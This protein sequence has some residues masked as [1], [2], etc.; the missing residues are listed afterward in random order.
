[1]A[2]ICDPDFYIPTMPR[3]T[4]TGRESGLH[5]R[6]GPRARRA[7]GKARTGHTRGGPEKV[8]TNLA[9]MGFEENTGLMRLETLHPG[10][11]VEDVKANT[12]FDLAIPEKVL[13]TEPPTV[14][15]VELIRNKIDLHG[16]RKQR[17]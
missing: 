16:L 11:A 4:G 15:Q 13:E 1:M 10:V 9:V 2:I 14:E 6:H 7:Q 12:G 3:K 8:F 5:N 17:F